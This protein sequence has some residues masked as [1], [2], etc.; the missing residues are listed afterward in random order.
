ML[1]FSYRFIYFIARCFPIF[2][3][4]LITQL[5]IEHFVIKIFLD[6]FLLSFGIYNQIYCCFISV[7]MSYF[8]CWKS[9][10]EYSVELIWFFKANWS[11]IP[12]NVDECPT[13]ERMC[14]LAKDLEI[15]FKN[16]LNLCLK[17]SAFVWNCKSC[18][19]LVPQNYYKL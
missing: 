8:S 18:R 5:Q 13:D 6:F 9:L 3:A 10:K 14:K 2:I 1:F 15:F 4:V 7:C 17:V 16:Y 11:E 19:H 12:I